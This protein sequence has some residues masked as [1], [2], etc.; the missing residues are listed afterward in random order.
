MLNFTSNG[1]R[2]SLR[3]GSGWLVVEPTPLKNI[4]QIGNLPKKNGGEN[5]K[6]FETTT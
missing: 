6:I 1:D 5:N 3:A 4:R 2:K